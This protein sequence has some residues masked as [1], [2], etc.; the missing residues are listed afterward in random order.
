ML[1][2]TGAA[3]SLP[4]LEVMTG[5][6]TRAAETAKPTTRLAYMYIP[7]GVAEGAWQP[8]TVGAK[9]QLQ[10]LNPWMRS[11]EKHREDLSLIHI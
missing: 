4:L 6:T 5:R 11:L 8:K 1:R 3:V 7:N 2:G 9:D 10:Q